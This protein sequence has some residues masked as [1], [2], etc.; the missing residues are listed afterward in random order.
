MTTR[1]STAAYSLITCRD[2]YRLTH[3][4]QILNVRVPSATYIFLQAFVIANNRI[5]LTLTHWKKKKK[6]GRT[7]LMALAPTESMKLAGVQSRMMEW[8]VLRGLRNTTSSKS[9]SLCLTPNWPF[10][11]SSATWL[12]DKTSWVTPCSLY[13]KPIKETL[14]QRSW[15]SPK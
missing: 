15:I 13:W 14:K 7:C 4:G 6:K 5:T 9:D 11:S 3:W 10:I 12:W 2:R 8:M 1:T